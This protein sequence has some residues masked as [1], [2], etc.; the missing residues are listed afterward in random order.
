MVQ[1]SRAISSEPSTSKGP[2]RLEANPGH[3]NDIGR[4]PHGLLGQ[5]SLRPI[6]IRLSGPMWS[7][8]Q[9]KAGN[10]G[11]LGNGVLGLLPGVPLM[12]TK[13]KNQPVGIRPLS[14]RTC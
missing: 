11:A 7:V 2:A 13:N 5:S 3:N 4:C 1:R 9:I 6:S 12:I 14:L 8:R 10:K